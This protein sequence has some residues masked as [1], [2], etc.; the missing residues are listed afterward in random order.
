[1]TGDGRSTQSSANAGGGSNISSKWMYFDDESVEEVPA[2]TTVPT[3]G[4]T[5]TPGG[6]ATGAADRIVSDKA[7]V[8]FYRRRVLTTSNIINSIS[9]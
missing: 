1:M 6:V 7:Y 9:L 3:P 5:A 2:G 4:T 8:L